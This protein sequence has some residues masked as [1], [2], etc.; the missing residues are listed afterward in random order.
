MTGLFSKTSNN[1]SSRK[2]QLRRLVKKRQYGDALEIGLE[3][4][5][6]YPHEN[7]VL[8]IVGGIYYMKGKFKTAISYFDRALEI[9]EYD[10]DVLLLKATCHLELDETKRAIQCCDK[11]KEIDPKNKTLK[12]L[13]G[14]IESKN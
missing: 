11:V 14:K 6:K 2:K 4:L 12:E 9:G 13:L 7:D 8:S 3:I 1:L 10:I 5:P